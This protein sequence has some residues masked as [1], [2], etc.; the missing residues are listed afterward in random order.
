MV[1]R[2]LNLGV[3]SDSSFHGSTSIVVLNPESNV[4]DKRSVVFGDRALHLD[5]KVEIRTRN[6]DVNQKQRA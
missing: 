4:G 1:E 6:R 2:E 5:H 3:V